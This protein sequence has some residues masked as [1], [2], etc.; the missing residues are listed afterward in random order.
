M[1]QVQCVLLVGLHTHFFSALHAFLVQS[2]DKH[3]YSISFTNMKNPKNSW[4]SNMLT[5]MLK[6]DQ[7]GIMLV[8]GLLCFVNCVVNNAENQ[9]KTAKYLLLH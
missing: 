6:E 1:R 3:D 7:I 8:L 9:C 4:P 5:V 2:S